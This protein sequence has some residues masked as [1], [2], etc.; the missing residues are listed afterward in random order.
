MKILYSALLVGAILLGGCRQKNSDPQP[1]AYNM[2]F[3]IKGQ[4]VQCN[5]VFTETLNSDGS[6]STLVYSRNEYPSILLGF[7]RDKGAPMS[8]TY[9][10]T[11][12]YFPEQDLTKSKSLSTVSPSHPDSKLNSLRE[13]GSN[14]RSGSFSASYVENTTTVTATGTFTKVPLQN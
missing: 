10:T 12:T 13:D 3:T 6:T 9:L 2:T 14:L 1:P 7:M 5:A 4:P 11:I 8:A